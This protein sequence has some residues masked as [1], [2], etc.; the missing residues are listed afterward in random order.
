MGPEQ[1]THPRLQILS[2]MKTVSGVKMGHKLTKQ[3]NNSVARNISLA[4]TQAARCQYRAE[5]G[6]E[7]SP[8]L[9]L[10]FHQMCQ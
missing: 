3:T 7:A 1:K 6:A 8:P 10:V 4:K 5:A 9:Q 2:H